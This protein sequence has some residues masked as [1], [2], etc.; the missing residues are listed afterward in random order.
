MSINEASEHRSQELIDLISEASLKKITRIGKDGTLEEIITNDPETIYWKTQI[1]NSPTFARFVLELKNFEN[2]ANQ[3]K[4]NMSDSRAF[5]LSEQ[6]KDIVQSLKY[7]VDSKSSESL[8][9]EHNTQSTLI[10]KLNRTKIEKSFTIRDT[11]KKSMFAAFLGK[12]ESND[13]TNS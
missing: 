7:S 13:I 2:L 9:N 5:I 10:D 1:V 4:N 3:A 12:S 11:V 6:I 8:R